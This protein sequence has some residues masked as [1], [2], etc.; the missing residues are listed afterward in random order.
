M[1]VCV[2]KCGA[3]EG[4]RDHLDQSCD[5]WRIITKSQ[6]GEEYSTSNERRKTNWIGHICL[7]KYVIGGKVKERIEVTERRGRRR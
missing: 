3:V 2:L 1:C 5:R 4:W 6:G 7:L